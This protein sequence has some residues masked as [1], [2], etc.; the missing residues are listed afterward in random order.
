[1]RTAAL[2]NLGCKVNYYETEAMREL[3]ENAGYEIVDF[4]DKADVYVI[5]TCTVTNIADR[6]SRQMLRRARKLN[7]DSVIVAAGCYVQNADRNGFAND[8]LSYVDIIIGNDEKTKLIRALDELFKSREEAV[9]GCVGDVRYVDGIDGS[10]AI[11]EMV[12]TGQKDRS[13]VFLKV[14]DGCDMF[15]TYCV[16]PY[17]RGRVRSSSPEN[18][19]KSIHNLEK[20]G[21]KEVVLNG[22]HLSSYGKDIGTNLLSLLRLVDSEVSNM[23]IRLGSLEMSYITKESALGMAELKSICPHFHLSLQSG[24]DTVLKRMGRRYDTEGFLEKIEILREY[25]KKPA[26]TTDIIC[27]F[28]GE[29][30][31]EFEKTRE[32]VRK[33]GF[34]DVHVFPYSR[35]AGTRA[36]RMEGQLPEAVKKERVRILM[37][38]VAVLKKEYEDSLLGTEVHVL[39][40]EKK[41]IDNVLAS[42]GHSERYLEV[43]S[44]TAI[45]DEIISGC[46]KRDKFG[47][48]WVQE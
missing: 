23:R 46:L 32:F 43:Y 36:D 15:C 48:L 47:K 39:I 34:F 25:F 17:V 8:D 19:I 2:H 42:F 37:D 27:G 9:D 45:E 31:E 12:V 22:I 11:E 26:F 33:V 35:R 28:P 7:P 14:E 5:N 40:E 3:L 24:C 13:R 18:I 41:S 38:D 16:I 44:N 21:C 10:G 1:M 29:T 30:D 6:K 4:H 20:T